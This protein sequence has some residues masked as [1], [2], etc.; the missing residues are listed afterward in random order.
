[1]NGI[2][3]MGW[4]KPSYGRSI[5]SRGSWTEGYSSSLLF[6]LNDK[7]NLIKITV[8]KII[9]KNQDLSGID[10]Y[11]NDIKLTNIQIK[12]TKEIYIDLK[13]EKFKN[14]VNIITFNIKNPITPFSLLKSVD[15]RLLGL[16][17]K[18]VEF[19]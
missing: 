18:E 17:I 6:T 5:K 13:N 3:G 9:L 8:D 15:G 11:F 12:D 10:I 1:M 16:L 4:S 2:L 19:Q 7:I 14:D